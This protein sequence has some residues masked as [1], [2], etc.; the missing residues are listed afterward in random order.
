MD[1]TPALT[2][3]Q[4]R[5]TSTSPL[6]VDSQANDDL[7]RPIPPHQ[8][9]DNNLSSEDENQS[10]SAGAPP[11]SVPLTQEQTIL[12]LSPILDALTQLNSRMTTLQH[13]FEW[14]QHRLSDLDNQFQELRLKS[15][16][17]VVEPLQPPVPPAPTA[18]SHNVKPSFNSS[19]SEQ[20]TGLTAAFATPAAAPPRIIST[21]IEDQLTNPTPNLKLD[22]K[23]KRFKSNSAWL[24]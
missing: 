16:T 15:E 20:H 19:S 11:S 18:D 23:V 17:P 10:S 14:T 2:R 3:Q 9:E 7:L 5:L 8:D 22:F 13:S 4:A 6:T 24:P 12:Q 1:Y 21:G